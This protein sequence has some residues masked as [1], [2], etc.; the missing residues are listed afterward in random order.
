MARVRAHME[1]FASEHNAHTIVIVGNKSIATIDDAARCLVQEMVT[2]DEKQNKIKF[3][4][5]SY[6]ECES[7]EIVQ[8]YRDKHH[9]KLVAARCVKQAKIT[10]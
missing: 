4:F 10:V 8:N 7:S 2:V 5:G 1:G 9:I 3:S 6:I